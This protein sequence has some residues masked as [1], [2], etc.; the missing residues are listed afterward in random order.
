MQRKTSTTPTMIMTWGCLPPTAGLPLLDEQL[1]LANRY[2]NALVE[3]EQT[4]RERR[5]ALLARLLPDDLVDAHEAVDAMCADLSDEMKRA[6]ARKKALPST[7]KKKR[8]G[9]PGDVTTT[10]LAALQELLAVVRAERK[11]T[12]KLY[13]EARRKVT[14]AVLFADPKASEKLRKRLDKAQAEA[15][16]QGRT[17]KQQ[18]AAE[19]KLETARTTLEEYEAMKDSPVDPEVAAVGEDLAVVYAEEN[20][21]IKSARAASGLYWGTYLLVEK[22]MEEARK[23]MEAPSF[24]RHDGSGRIGVHIMG[25]MSAAEVMDGEDTQLRIVA[26]SGIAPRSRRPGQPGAPT[27]GTFDHRS[28]AERLA[29]PPAGWGTRMEPSARQAKWQTLTEAERLGSSG[30]WQRDIGSRRMVQIRAGS[31][32]DR[33]PVWITLPVVLQRPLPSDGR[34]K[35]A[36]IIRRRVGVRFSYDLQI[37]VEAESFA[38]PAEPVGHGTCAINLGWRWRGDEVRACYLVD[39]EGHEEELLV[40][41]YRP[42]HGDRAKITTFGVEK[43][44]ELRSIRDGNFEIVRDALAAWIATQPVTPAAGSPEDLDRELRYLDWLRSETRFLARWRAQRK[45][46]WLLSRWRERRCEGDSKI[47]ARVE[48][49][50][51]QDRHLLDWESYQR[52][53]QVQRRKCI[54]REWATKIARRYARIIICEMVIPKLPGM[55]VLKPEEGDP[56]EG[57]DQRWTERLAAVGELREI[58]RRAAAKT[59]ATVEEKEPDQWTQRCN[60]CGAQPPA[61]PKWDAARAVMHSCV[62]CRALWDQDANHCRNLLADDASGEVVT[63]AAEPLAEA[64]EVESG[65]N[66]EMGSNSRGIAWRSRR[67]WPSRR[68]R[69]AGR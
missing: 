5:Q 49:W 42:R 37:Q 4:K 53:R 36:W 55:R 33:S 7:P 6:K 26:S 13:Y 30:R 1:R 34:V 25:G 22:S 57:R 50:A 47:F 17:K 48:A 16:K 3:I 54:W 31:N 18:A 62:G 14:L 28:E 41:R 15:A 29:T 2:R 12:S 9:V 60:P 67:R 19:K 11:E 24:E 39:D 40:P 32:P 44:R 51:K 20:R 46:A 63:G 38:P 58:V 23:A 10:D 69:A 59:A 27:L 64:K 61:V 52:R 8:D 68:G 65:G 45:L 21:A 66:S 56:S 35:A 43:P